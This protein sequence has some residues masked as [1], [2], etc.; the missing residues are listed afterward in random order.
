MFCGQIGEII[1]VMNKLIVTLT[2]V[3]LAL[4]CKAAKS[5]APPGIE[6]DSKGSWL[7]HSCQASI[8]AEDAG[9]NANP[10]DIEDAN[11]CIDYLAGFIDG[12]SPTTLFC[13]GNATVGTLI[14][15]Y[16]NFMQ[17]HPK[18]RDE[19]RGIGLIAA[20]HANYPCPNK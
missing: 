3:I 12:S 16:V 6:D 15:I 13:P 10:T 1:V 18:Y 2:A 8:R 11:H 14:R 4:A 9:S 20:L 7:H 17:R 19:Q 5:Q